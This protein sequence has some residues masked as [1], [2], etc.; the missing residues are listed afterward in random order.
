LQYGY[1]WEG[2]F[3][4]NEKFAELNAVLDRVAVEQDVTPAAVAIA[5]I[6]RHPAKIQAIMGTTKPERVK[7]I[8]KACRVEMSRPLWYEIYLAAGNNLP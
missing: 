3:L 5:W 7:E 8:A 6:L 1:F 4:E 2:T